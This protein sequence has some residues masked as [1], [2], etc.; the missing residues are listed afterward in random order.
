MITT[1]EDII[2]KANPKQQSL[3]QRLN[4][5]DQKELHKVVIEEIKDFAK[6][7]DNEEAI[8]LYARILIKKYVET[9][10]ENRLNRI[11]INIK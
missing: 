2:K 1:Y 6:D 3:K 4:S 8:A 7:V 9:V 10:I 5:N 11:L